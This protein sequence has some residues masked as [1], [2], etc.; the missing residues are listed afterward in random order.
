MSLMKTIS[1]LKLLNNDGVLTDEQ[2]RM[3]WDIHLKKRFSLYYELRTCVYVGVLFIL[4][5]LGLTI[6]QYFIQLGDIA[7]ITFL[8]VSTLAAFIYC[9]M[10][11]DAY[12][13]DEAAAPNLAL[14]FILF[15]GCTAYSL[16]IAYIETQ[17]HILADLWVNYLLVSAGL[18]L[19]LAYR[20][21][22]RLVLSLALSTLAAWFGFKLYDP[23]IHFQEYHRLYAIAYALIVFAVGISLYRSAIK[24]HFLDIY[25]NFSAHFIFIALISGIVQYKIF[26]LYFFALV[27]SCITAAIYAIHARR[28]LYILYAIL[29]GY[30][31]LSIIAVDVLHHDGE[32][33]LFIYFILSSMGVVGLLYFLSRRFKEAP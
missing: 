20:F 1:L 16:N 22:S 15:F 13:P 18:F 7:I 4:A 27:A 8:S 28:F 11:G 19:Y 29:Y 17:F 31:G 32:G 12:S 23:L 21:D 30:V 3:L 5:G 10:K 9:F 14:D 33:F 25:L 2:Y 6:K 24:R 26:S